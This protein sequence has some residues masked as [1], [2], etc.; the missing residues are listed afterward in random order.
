MQDEEFQHAAGPLEVGRGPSSKGIS[1]LEVRDNQVSRDQLRLEERAG[2]MIELENLSLRNPVSIAG[3]RM[4]G[5]G[6]RREL[7]LPVLLL[8]AAC[9]IGIRQ[10][11]SASAERQEVN[12]AAEEAIPDP[13]DAELENP[14]SCFQQLQP[15]AGIKQALGSK[16]SSVDLASS[17]PRLRV[18]GRARMQQA[19]GAS[20]TPDKVAGCLEAIL[21]LQQVAA[22]SPEFFRQVAEAVLQYID[23]DLALV[24]LRQDKNWQVLGCAT[25][26][27]RVSV[28]YSQTL[29]KQIVAER[30]TYYQDYRVQPPQESESLRGLEAVVA[31]PI[32]NVQS[33]VMGVLYG[34]RMCTVTKRDGIQPLE[35]QIV[36]LLAAAVGAHMARSA[37][38]RTRVQFEQFFS[39]ELAQELERD[40][41][42]LEGRDQEVTVLF[43]DLRDFTALS[44]RLGPQDMCRLVRD[45]MERL[46]AAIAAQGGVIVDYAGDGILAMWNAPAPQA[47][48]AER[49]CRAAL[50]M[51][52]ELAGLNGRWRERAQMALRLG[53]G[54]NT[55]SA[56]V[57]NTGSSRKFK[58]GP[59]GPTV[60]L[61]SRVQD[62]TKRLGLPL[63]ITASTRALL[64]AAFAARRLGHYRLP[65]VHEP[66]V[67]Y[68]VYGESAPLGWQA[69]ADIYETVLSLFE[70]GQWSKACE[71][72]LSLLTLSEPLDACDPPTLKL[73]KRIWECLESR[74]EK[75]EPV[76]E[77]FSK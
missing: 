8:I 33:K 17:K 44:E 6:E 14:D 3:Q 66:V 22:D 21:A 53:I 12:A 38:L 60:N 13:A 35:A 68:D 42:L 31:S 71:S 7:R 10:I 64:P 4:L 65:G 43:S 61:G 23:L 55:G 52:Q 45:L 15:L 77:A 20:P 74:P 27:D 41:S 32:F 69:R 57:G 5:I 67:L 49:A 70:S 59:R 24:L 26:D 76:I 9:R 47:D 18:P 62:A 63:L 75:F 34:V 40:P 28:R 2:G 36:Q 72:L 30:K 56:Q 51:L 19:L 48:H 29:V 11:P 50:G 73:M 37:A 46:S 54:V 1:R 25:A 58:Y 39:P 16:D